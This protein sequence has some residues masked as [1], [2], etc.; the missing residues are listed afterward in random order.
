MQ[1]WRHSSATL[2]QPASLEDWHY[3]K[4]DAGWRREGRV[5]VGVGVGGLLFI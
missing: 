5:G 4:G 1:G 2:P 3:N